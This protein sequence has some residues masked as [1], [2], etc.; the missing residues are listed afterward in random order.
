MIFDNKKSDFMPGKV[1][2]D[3]PTENKRF[4]VF[5]RISTFMK[6]QKQEKPKVGKEKTIREKYDAK[7]EEQEK[8]LSVE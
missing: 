1:S 8:I 4:G 6:E 5:D 2:L 7:K 3:K